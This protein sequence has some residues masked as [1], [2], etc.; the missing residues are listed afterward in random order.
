MEDL[1][2]DR[3]ITMSSNYIRNVVCRR[4]CW[5]RSSSPPATSPPS[6]QDDFTA[7]GQLLRLAGLLAGLLATPGGRG[8]APAKGDPGSGQAVQE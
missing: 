6:S 1:G 7:A 5:R 4:S 8:Q 3:L 2:S